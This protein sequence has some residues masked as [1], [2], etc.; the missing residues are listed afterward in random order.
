MIPSLNEDLITELQSI[1]EQEYGRRFSPEETVAIGGML[2][3][4]YGNLAKNDLELGGDDKRK[5]SEMEY[6]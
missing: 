5:E 3:R 1:L 4:L 2:V 6:N